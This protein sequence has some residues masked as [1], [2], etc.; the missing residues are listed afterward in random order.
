G[1]AGD[2]ARGQPG[3][4]VVSMSWGANEFSNESSF[5]ST[6][7]TP[8]GHTGVAFVAASGDAG[9]PPEWPAISANVLGVGGTSLQLDG[10]GNYQG[11]FGWGGS[12]GGISAFLSQP[13]Y[14]NRVVTQTS[15]RRAS[16]DVAYDGDPATGFPVYDSFNNGTAAPWSQFGGTSAG[17]PQWAA[18]VAIA[19]QGRV[20]AGKAAL[21][22][23]S[24]LLPMLYG[25]PAP[26]FHDVTAG[27]SFGQPNFRAG[28]GY[29]LVTGR[30]TPVANLVA[31]DLV[32]PSA[33]AGVLQ[34]AGFESPAVGSGSLGA[35]QYDPAGSP[36]AYTG[37][38]G[39]AGDG[40]GFT[41]GNPNAP[42]G[43]QVGFLQGTGAFSQ[44]VAGLAAG[45]Y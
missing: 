26:D 18:L 29:D 35:F 5:D 33:A 32:C 13:A 8:A 42:E 28:P 24:Q 22:G 38:A 11:E 4:A 45:T 14:Q 2:S 44:T 41:A 3:V 39:V 30:G 7:T 10:A 9:A 16:P 1:G 37:Q 43:T 15:T 20:L 31:A 19:D 40:S 17:S 34:E 12:G 36:W 23:P 6:F 25:L 21:D 27:T